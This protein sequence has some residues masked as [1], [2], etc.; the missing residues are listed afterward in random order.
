[1]VIKIGK[2]GSGSTVEYPA[3]FEEVIAVG[4]IT[5]QGEMS[6]ISSVGTEV[7][8]LAPGEMV[9]TT[10]YFDEIIKTEGTSMAAPHI[11]G[12]ASVL[13]AK[14]KSKSGEF[15]RAL[16]NESAKQIGDE[17]GQGNG[18]VDLEYA[19]SIYDEFES[20]YVEYIDENEDIVEK[21]IKELETYTETELEA[22]WSYSNHAYAVGLY[23]EMSEGALS[24]VKIGS[25]IP[26]TASYLKYLHGKTDSFH[27]HY[28]YVANY[29]YVMR[30]A[31]ICWNSGMTAALKNA[32]YPCGGKGE[33][34]IYNGIVNLNKNWST[35]LAG[36]TINNKNKARVLVGIAIHIAMDTYA[37]KA[38]IKD[39]NGKWSVHISGN[40]N[41]D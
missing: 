40:A 6:K 15:I 13:W 3:A 4:A 1:M 11:T 35:V 2:N 8:L 12:V 36:K 23:E 7:E 37:H 26:D 39:S 27:G 10:G 21:N 9:P 16:M 5:P 19:L 25:K 28:N 20:K 41:Q 17:A 14:D 34:Q 32:E 24:I 30:M 31:R 33:E 38:Y 29:I 22:S 18:V